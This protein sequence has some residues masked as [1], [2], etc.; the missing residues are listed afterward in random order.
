MGFDGEIQIRSAVGIQVAISVAYGT[1]TKI[2]DRFSCLSCL[3]AGRRGIG[4]FL[5]QLAGMSDVQRAGGV[6]DNAIASVFRIDHEHD[7]SSEGMSEQEDSFPVE[8]LEF[9]TAFEGGE[10]RLRFQH[11]VSDRHVGLPVGQTHEKKIIQFSNRSNG[12]WHVFGGIFAFGI[13]KRGSVQQQYHVHG[14]S[15]RLRNV[16]G[17]A[18]RASPYRHFFL[19]IRFREIQRFIT[20]AGSASI[21]DDR[22][23]I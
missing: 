12:N 15:C 7:V 4:I 8:I 18:Q 11:H 10:N 16:R 9:R 13:V 3:A 21:H 17:Q 22:A 5:D 1:R 19:G 20:D 2:T 23:G 14:S 6:R